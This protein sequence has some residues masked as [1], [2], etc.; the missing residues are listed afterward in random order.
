[1]CSILPDHLARP[2]S[3]PVIH[4]GISAREISPGSTYILCADQVSGLP[5]RLT[6]LAPVVA[7]SH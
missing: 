6:W 3:N 2:N 1:M 4:K 7:V 5:Q